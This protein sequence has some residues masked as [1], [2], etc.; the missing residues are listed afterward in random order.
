MFT[1][2]MKFSGKWHLWIRNTDREINQD[3]VLSYEENVRINSVYV[4]QFFT[5]T[6]GGDIQS[7][8][9][10]ISIKPDMRTYLQA[11]YISKNR[12]QAVWAT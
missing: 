11:F 1:I 4:E 7:V 3:L 5:I 9:S 6:L 12:F 8:I 2:Y 10:S